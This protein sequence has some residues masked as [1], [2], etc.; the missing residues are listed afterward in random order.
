MLGRSSTPRPARADRSVSGTWYLV[1]SLLQGLG[2]LL[3]QPFAVRIL[4]ERQWGYV[5]TSVVTIQVLVVLISAGLPLAI[6]NLWFARE[7]GQDRSREMYG[8]MAIASA[9]LAAASALGLLGLG[10]L[11]GEGVAS[12]TVLSVVSVGILGTVLGSQ[13]VLRAQNRPGRFVLLSIGSSVLANLLGLLG[14]IFIAPTAEVY[15]GAYSLAVLGSGVAALVLARPRPPWKVPGSGRES[16]KIAVP[17]LP[18]TGALMLLTQGSVLILAYAA[19]VE[20]AGHF[21]TVLIFALGPITILNALNNAWST[22]MMSAGEDQL[23]DETRRVSL[24]AVAWAVGVGLL[25]ASGAA[26]GSFILSTEP[27]LVWPIA[28]TLPLVSIGYALFLVASNLLYIADGTRRLAFVTPGVLVVVAVLAWWPASEA[29]LVVVAMIQVLG[30]ACLG[31]LTYAMVL[32][33]PPGRS[34]PLALFLGGFGLQVGVVVLLGLVPL[35]FIAG[36]I[37]VAVIVALLVVLFLLRSRR[38]AVQTL[39]GSAKH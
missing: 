19:A 5:S 16:L 7:R 24:E 37:E 26:V 17:L 38:K 22:R 9:A 2:L 29:D 11:T 3:I 21:G 23:V 33:T 12:T 32:R 35:S 39:S 34:V 18:H 25:A 8:F 28:I 4:D 20:D 36:V 27:G 31:L 15:M 6:T 30:F 14:I 13:A 10:A 1:G